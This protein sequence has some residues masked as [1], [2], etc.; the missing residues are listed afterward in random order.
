MNRDTP[1]EVKLMH[2][3]WENPRVGREFQELTATLISEY[4]GV[5]FDTEIPMM[6]GN[7]AKAHKFDCVS[8]DRKIAVECKCYTWTHTGNIPS[9][10]LGFLNQ[11]VLYAS[12]LPVGVKRVIAMK[13]SLHPR[14]QE[15]LA[16]YYYRTYQHLLA[17][18]VILEIDTEL[19]TI[20]EINPERK[21]LS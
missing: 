14:R 10:K 3:N 7:P 17:G 2:A 21:P 5:H 9:A 20:R 16:E 18:I 8:I 4:Y 12:L 11:A 1:G 19:N 6:I 13:R 15:S